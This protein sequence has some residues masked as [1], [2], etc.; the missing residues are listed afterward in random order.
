MKTKFRYRTCRH[1]AGIKRIEGGDWFDVVVP[2]DVTLRKD[3]Y[4][5]IPLGICVEL[6]KGYEAHLL[7][8]SSTFSKYKVLLVNGMGVID[9]SYCGDGDEWKCLFY[10]TTDS[11]IPAGARVMQFRIQLTQ[12]AS[13]W[14]KIKWLFSRGVSMEKV[15]TFGN[16]D[17]GGVGSTGNF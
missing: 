5:M 4:V 9:C 15:Y 2:E 7:P 14:Q 12:H 1:N 13:V 8:R 16:K 11:F 10:P 3:E 6:P 17:R